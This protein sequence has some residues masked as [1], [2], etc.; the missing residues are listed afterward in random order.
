MPAASSACARRASPDTVCA[1]GRTSVAERLEFTLVE[2]VAEMRQNNWLRRYGR[3][4]TLAF[5]LAAV[6]LAATVLVV[7]DPKGTAGFHDAQGFACKMSF[8]FTPVAMDASR[9]PSPLCWRE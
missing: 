9:S 5:A 3:L 7:I 6:T 1:S 4:V 8:A 2:L